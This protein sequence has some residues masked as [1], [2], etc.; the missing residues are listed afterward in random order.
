M[1]DQSNGRTFAKRM[2]Q[3]WA[4]NKSSQNEDFWTGTTPAAHNNSTFCLLFTSVSVFLILLFSQSWFKVI[5]HQNI[6]V[7]HMPTYPNPV[8]FFLLTSILRFFVNQLCVFVVS[9]LRHIYFGSVKVAFKSAHDML[10]FN[11]QKS[12]VVL[13]LTS[14]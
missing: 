14:A 4:V 9:K 3:R 7:V 13:Y 12:F 10:S 6:F 5:V 11:F 1:R 2:T 8:I